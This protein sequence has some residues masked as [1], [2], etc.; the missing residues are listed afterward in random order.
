M[1]TD[2]IL[3]FSFALLLSFPFFM[4]LRHFV[5]HYIQLKNKELKLLGVKAHGE[6]RLQAYER[7]TLFLERI[8]PS[9]LV[10]KF[11]KELEVHEYIF[12]LEKNILEEFEYNSSQQLYISKG[13][14]ENIVAS[15]NNVVHLLRNTYSSMDT[16]PLQDFKTV[17]L[18]NYMNGE[19]FI[20]QTIEELRK[21]TVLLS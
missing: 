4:L 7:L 18:M 10:N 3:I 16:V 15:K 6:L 1:K 11:D 19:D 17:F 13:T 14:W 20:A 2:Q 5:Y 9:G 12:L 21:E 8:K